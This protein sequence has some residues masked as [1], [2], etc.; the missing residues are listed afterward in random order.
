MFTFVS[1]F[2]SLRLNRIMKT[3]LILGT[4]LLWFSASSALQAITYEKDIMPIFMEKCADCHSSEGKVKG[5]LKLDDPKHFLGRFEKND[6]VIPGDWDASYLFITLFRPPEA[7]E[8]MPPKGKGERLTME[9]V[10]LV[11]RWIAEGA[12]I[13]GVKG[14]TG[15]MPEKPEDMFLDL[16]VFPPPTGGGDGGETMT[17]SK[18]MMAEKEAPKPEEWT[19]HEGKPITATLVGL[20]DGKAL[21]KMENGTVYKYPVKDLS[22]ESQAKIKERFAH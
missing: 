12:E 5:G 22:A 2:A 19:N 15:F 17:D 1:L 20:E 13:D 11:Q 16:G 10:I 9:E 21:L 7:E 3:A 18:P 14:E 6:V 4:T 8:A